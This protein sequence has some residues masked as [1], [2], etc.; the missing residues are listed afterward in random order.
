MRYSEVDMAHMMIV[1]GWICLF[2]HY[3]KTN[4]VGAHLGDSNKHKQNS[5]FTGN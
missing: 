2:L 4:V 5:C 3:D 1:K